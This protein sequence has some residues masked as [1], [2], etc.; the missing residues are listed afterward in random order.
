MYI[1]A[2]ESLV[3]QIVIIALT[4]IEFRKG[5]M[6]L[7]CLRGNS[8]VKAANKKPLRVMGAA[9]DEDYEEGIPDMD[10]KTLIRARYEHEEREV[11]LRKVALSKLLKQVN[12]A[13]D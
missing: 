10:E 13:F 12:M 7:D 1:L 6:Y 11:N 3:L 9:T 8:M 4:V 5:A 2:V